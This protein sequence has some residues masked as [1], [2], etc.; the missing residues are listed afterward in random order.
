MPVIGIRSLIHTCSKM[1]EEQS[2]QANTRARLRSVHDEPLAPDHQR[3]KRPHAET[4]DNTSS[5]PDEYEVVNAR[6]DPTFSGVMVK[7]PES[8]PRRSRYWIGY[9]VARLCPIQGEKVRIRAR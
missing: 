8:P 5:S 4:P 3:R 6:N 9:M 2:H 7:L 1:D